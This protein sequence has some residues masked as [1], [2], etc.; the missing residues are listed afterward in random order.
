MYLLQ[1]FYIS[2]WHNWQNKLYFRDAFG[3]RIPNL[4]GIGGVQKKIKGQTGFKETEGSIH[5][6]MQVECV[7]MTPGASHSFLLWPYILILTRSLF[8]HLLMNGNIIP[9]PSG[10]CSAQCWNCL[11]SEL[12]FCQPS[13]IKMG[14]GYPTICYCLVKDCQDAVNHARVV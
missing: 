14:N 2:I 1:Y 11:C 6:H 10:F 4:N 3:H 12:L 8:A 13:A 5:E 9:L 7:H